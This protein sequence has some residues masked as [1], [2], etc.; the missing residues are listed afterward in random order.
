MLGLVLALITGYAGFVSL[1]PL[2]FL[3]G[4]LIWRYVLP[5]FASRSSY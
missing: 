4:D 5:R 2:V 3:V 1:V